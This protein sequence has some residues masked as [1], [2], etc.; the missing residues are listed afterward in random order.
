MAE[1]CTNV[2]IAHRLCVTEGTIEKHVHSILSKL[3]LP[4]TEAI[5]GGS[6]PC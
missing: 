2:G 6:W 4:E 3:D 1:G 5:T